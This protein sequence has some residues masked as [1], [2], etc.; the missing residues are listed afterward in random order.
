MYLVL[1]RVS[2]AATLKPNRLCY[3]LST[4]LSEQD[5]FF[6]LSDV[7]YYLSSMVKFFIYCTKICEQSVKKLKKIIQAC[8]FNNRN[9]RVLYYLKDHTW[10]MRL[11][12]FPGDI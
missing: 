10:I 9:L 5:G 1:E 4:Y 2:N 3:V 7:Y 11:S 6:L 8:S 12:G